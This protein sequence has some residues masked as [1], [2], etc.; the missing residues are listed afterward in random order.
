[1]LPHLFLFGPVLL[2]L[3]SFVGAYLLKDNLELVEQIWILVIDAAGVWQVRP[4]HPCTK[5]E[6]PNSRVSAN[7]DFTGN[8]NLD[9]L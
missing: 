6:H 1:L 8:P 4:L 3:R 9:L 7:N 5:T 2:L